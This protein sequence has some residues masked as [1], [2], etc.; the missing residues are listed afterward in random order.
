MTDE[1]LCRLRDSLVCAS[2]WDE[3]DLAADVREH[4]ARL[5]LL[6]LPGS[7]PMATAPRDG[8]R[9]LVFG[10]CRLTGYRV[11]PG[12]EDWAWHIVH[13]DTLDLDG[14][15][16]YWSDGYEGWIPAALCWVPMPP[17]PDARTLRRIAK[18]VTPEMV[19]NDRH[20]NGAPK[21]AGGGTLLDDRGK[22]SIFDDV[23][24]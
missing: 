15:G 23:D 9:I 14:D 5:N 20:P 12:D 4:L 19:S 10:D 22:R 13:W 3:A 11:E 24:E 21:W 17:I 16:G 1:L 18:G 2:G 7:Q 6:V 8:T